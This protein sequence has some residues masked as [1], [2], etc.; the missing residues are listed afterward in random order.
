MQEGA[1]SCLT[2]FLLRDSQENGA[3]LI[4]ISLENRQNVNEA[5]KIPKRKYTRK[6]SV[7]W[8]DRR[9]VTFAG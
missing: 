3:I 2:D 7:L 5:F 4:G 1:A 9:A 6:L 8:S